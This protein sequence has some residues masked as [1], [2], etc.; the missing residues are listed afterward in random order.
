MHHETFHEWFRKHVE[1]LIEN[2]ADVSEEIKFLARRMMVEVGEKRKAAEVTEYEKQR[3]ANIEKNNQ[4]MHSLKLPS[5]AH[6]V[7]S[8]AQ[9]RKRKVVDH[10]VERSEPAIGRNLRSSSRATS[11]HDRGLFDWLMQKAAAQWKEFKAVLKEFLKKY[12]DE[13]EE[14]ELLDLCDERLHEDDWK[15]LLDHWR[16]GSLRAIANRAKL[17][18]NHTSGSK[19]HARVEEEQ[20]EELGHSPRRDEVFIKSHTHK[21]GQPEKGSEVTINA[22]KTAV[23]DHPELTQ[24][25]IQEGDVYFHVCGPE[26]NGYV[27]VVGLGPTPAGLE[28]PGAKKYTSTKLQMEIEARR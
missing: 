24:K 20:R 15:W 13:M 28:M 4:R 2:G 6:E 1:E 10:S 23:V 25:S 21:T 5:L 18:Q 11:P 9:Q 14:D 19:S 7:N 26:K 8:Q 17:T 16:L 3:L 22:L 27:H 12:N